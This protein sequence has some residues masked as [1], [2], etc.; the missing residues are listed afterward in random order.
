MDLGFARRNYSQRSPA[1][2][3]A[4]YR[5]LLASVSA[6]QAISPTARVQAAIK[7]KTT[8][9]MPNIFAS[10]D[11]VNGCK[12][13]AASFHAAVAGTIATEGKSL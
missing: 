5:M 11:Q 9:V 6:R 2:P 7:R 4:A 13:Q 10:T 3:V 8:H 12:A 1:D